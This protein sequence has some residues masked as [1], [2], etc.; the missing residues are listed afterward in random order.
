MASVQL[1]LITS[2]LP[3]VYAL[4]PAKID[5]LLP[6]KIDSLRRRRTSKIYSHLVTEIK[7]SLEIFHR[8]VNSTTHAP[9]D[10]LVTNGIAQ[11]LE[12]LFN[13]TVL[14]RGVSGQHLTRRE[15]ILL[16]LTEPV[17]R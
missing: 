14:T 9:G 2:V 12:N 1:E 17:Q 10:N 15:Y 6:A 3:H 8:Y 13:D 16:S 5:S 4:P 11:C 7:P